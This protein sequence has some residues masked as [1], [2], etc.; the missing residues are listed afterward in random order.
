MK[1]KIK[2]KE[3]IIQRNEYVKDGLLLSDDYIA[4]YFILS[5]VNK[6][7]ISDRNEILPPLTHINTH[8]RF[9]IGM[10]FEEI[11]KRN[12]EKERN[13]DDDDEE[14]KEDDGEENNEDKNEVGSKFKINPKLLNIVYFYYNNIRNQIF[15]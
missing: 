13:D 4:R 10:E 2:S 15:H 3:I 6:L 14:E 11:Y 12:L 1:K 9:A 8:S 7:K 5:M